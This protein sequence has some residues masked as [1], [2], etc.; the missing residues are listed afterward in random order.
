MEAK[1]IDLLKYRGGNSTLFTGRPQGKEVRNELKL[2]EE[3]KLSESVIFII[4]KGTTSFNP[5]FYL[6]LLFDSISNLGKEKFEIK[7]TF[8]FSSVED[9]YQNIISADLN[10]GMRH[11]LNSIEGGTGFDLFF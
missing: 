1:K 7:Y 3:D 9:D 8:D 5:S 4:P 2:V 10:D 11:A 6:G